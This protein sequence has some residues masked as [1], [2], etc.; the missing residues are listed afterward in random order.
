MEAHESDRGEAGKGRSLAYLR[1]SD[2]G[3]SRAR[4]PHHG[5]LAQ[6]G[7]QGDSAQEPEPDLLPDQRRRT[8]SGA[9]GG[10]D[11]AQARVRLVPAVLPRSRPLPHA[12][13]HA[14]ADAP[15]RGRRE[16]RPEL[17]RPPDA[18]PLGRHGAEHHF[19]VEPDGHAVP[20]RHRRGRSRQ[21]LPAG[22]RDR[23]PRVALPRRR[24]HVHVHRRRDDERRRV[25]GVAQ[26]RLHARA[27]GRLPD[28]RQRL[29]D[30]R[31]G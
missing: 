13:R 15:E 31:A 10:G 17:G 25:L 4:V 29:R 2:C 21:D 23:G 30:L 3:R 11:D 7:R 16:G 19:A 6:A 24:S 5:A 18:V 20:P 8:R 27:A 1:G 28:R 14:A 12:R 26:L 22:L 9:R